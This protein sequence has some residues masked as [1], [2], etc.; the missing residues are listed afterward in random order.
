MA[1]DPTDPIQDLE[2]PEAD[3]LE[4]ERDVTDADAPIPSDDDA[5]PHEPTSGPEKRE[6]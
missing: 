6:R 5:A 4:Q 2:K 3:R 1:D